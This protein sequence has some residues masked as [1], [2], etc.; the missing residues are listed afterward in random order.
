MEYITSRRNPL[1][2]HFKK[3]GISSAY[4]QESGEFLCDGIKLLG[5]A[6]KSGADVPAVLTASHIQFPLSEGTRLYYTNRELIDSLSPLKNAQDM[7]FTCRIPVANAG[8]D[9]FDEKAVE[10]TVDKFTEMTGTHILL[11]GV[12]DPGNVGAI[13]RTAN[14]F[15]IKSVILTSGCADLYNP[16]TIRA[17]MGAIFRQSIFHMS[18]SDIVR[19]RDNGV[20]LIGAALK[21]GCRSIS[22]VDLSNSVIAFGSEGSGLS[23][24]VMAIC[25]EKV[26]IPIAPE[27]ESLNAAAAAAVIMWEARKSV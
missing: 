5:D 22:D 21:E 17:S 8:A 18:L 23:E 25:S 9:D 24:E 16:K 3:L 19:L 10:I 13:I 6:L 7:L 4:R 14:A 2:V 11:D 20:R 26:T 1:A 12:Q 15:G 27:C